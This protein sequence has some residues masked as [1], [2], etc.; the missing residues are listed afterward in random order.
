MFGIEF[1][2]PS[3]EAPQ[4]LQQLTPSFTKRSAAGYSPVSTKRC[5]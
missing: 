1:D 4:Y 2:F 5:G 3:V